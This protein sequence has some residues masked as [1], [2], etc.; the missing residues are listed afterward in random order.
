MNY[1]TQQFV[2]CDACGEDFP[3]HMV[4][5]RFGNDLTCDACSEQI[6]RDFGQY[7]EE[8]TNSDMDD[9]AS[10]YDDDPNPYSG[11]YSEL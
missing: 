11:T 10:Q 1:E 2:P 9:W 5:N 4:S 3:Q 7:H 6:A 8:L